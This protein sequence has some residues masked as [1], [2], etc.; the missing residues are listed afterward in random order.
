MN[1]GAFAEL[2][3]RGARALARR[4][5]VA[6]CRWPPR[7]NVEHAHLILGSAMGKTPRRATQIGFFSLA[8]RRGARLRRGTRVPPRGRA[9][10]TQPTAGKVH[11]PAAAALPTPPPHHSSEQR[12]LVAA[13]WRQPT[14]VA[15]RSL[16]G[17]RHTSRRRERATRRSGAASAINRHLPAHSAPPG[18]TED[19]AVRR[20]LAKCTA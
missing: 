15:C 6:A 16:L 8:P 11:A 10:P 14:L 2:R 13:A 1:G 12:T 20:L 7:F 18:E 17:G 4:R 3:R 9:H 19:S 5:S